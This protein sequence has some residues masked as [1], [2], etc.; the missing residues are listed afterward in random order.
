MYCQLLSL[1]ARQIKSEVLEKLVFDYFWVAVSVD[2]LRKLF[3]NEF[4]QLVVHFLFVDE[5]S[6]GIIIYLNEDLSSFDSP[7]SFLYVNRL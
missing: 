2:Y 7:L 3:Q 1:I 6:F 4:D 5:P